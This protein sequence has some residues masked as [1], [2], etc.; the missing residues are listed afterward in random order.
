MARIDVGA[1]DQLH[2]R[3]HGRAAR[4]RQRVAGRQQAAAIDRHHRRGIELLGQRAHERPGILRAAAHQQHGRPGAVQPV[5]GLLQRGRRGGRRRGRD[6]GADRRQLVRR[7]CDDVE[8]QLDMDRARPAAGE[9]REGARHHLG[10]LGR[11]HHGM[12]EGADLLHQLP[13]V[14]QLMQP[15]FA[16]ADLAE[17]V[18][19]GNDQHG[20]GIAHRPGPSRSRCWSCRGR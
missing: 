6:D 14:L 13:L 10:Q 5:R 4:H 8:R 16:R 19:G 11:A 1:F 12:A 18:D 17:G 2:G 9:Q 15:A 7:G 20:D 3:R